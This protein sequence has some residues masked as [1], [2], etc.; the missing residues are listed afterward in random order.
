MTNHSVV[1]TEQEVISNQGF[2]FWRANMMISVTMRMNS[3][4]KLDS[5]GGEH[6]KE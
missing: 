4:E 6:Q 5:T 1:L 2:K 3:H